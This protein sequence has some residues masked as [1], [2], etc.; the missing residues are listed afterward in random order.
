M[1][2]LKLEGLMGQSYH[3]RQRMVHFMQSIVYYMMVKVTLLQFVTLQ[4]SVYPYFKAIRERRF[5]LKDFTCFLEGTPWI[6][7]CFRKLR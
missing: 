4:Q 5:P 2:Q 7:V 3:L 1:K 6:S